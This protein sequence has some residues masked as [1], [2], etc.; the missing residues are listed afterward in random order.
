MPALQLSRKNR[1]TGALGAIAAELALAAMIFW[2]L[3]VQF[4]RAPD[5]PPGLVTI[6][7][8]PEPSPMATPSDARE[9]EAAPPGR[10]AEPAPKEAPPAKI[11]LPPPEPAAPA[12][13]GPQAPRCRVPAPGPV[14]RAAA[15]ARVDQARAQARARRLPR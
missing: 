11:Q 2:G 4:A 3:T 12:R 7:V 13:L 8:S 9:G 15:P 5:R 14:V 10:E 6:T 1:A